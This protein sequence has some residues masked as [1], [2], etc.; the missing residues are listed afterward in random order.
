LRSCL[1]CAMAQRSIY[2]K[3]ARVL[4]KPQTCSLRAPLCMRART[5]PSASPDSPARAVASPSIDTG[6][7]T[8]GTTGTPA[9]ATGGTG[10]QTTGNGEGDRAA[11][12]VAAGEEPA[13]LEPSKLA[14]PQPAVAPVDE[15]DIA[16]LT[17]SPT[18]LSALKGPFPWW[19]RWTTAIGVSFSNGVLIPAQSKIFR[20]FQS[21]PP[22]D[23]HWR[24]RPHRS[25]AHCGLVFNRSRTQALR[26]PRRTFPLRPPRAARPLSRR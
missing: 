9:S 12:A 5:A 2:R 22:V 23:R 6:D 21:L 26:R 18:T 14:E 13:T 7:P 19:G 15:A 3:H 24:A 16:A 8:T 11:S 1:I 20:F 17:P 10:E 25:R 4:K